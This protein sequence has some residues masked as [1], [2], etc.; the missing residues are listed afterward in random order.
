[1]IT[2]PTPC[3]PT[4][5]SLF[6]ALDQIADKIEAIFDNGNAKDDVIGNGL[7]HSYTFT[8][9]DLL[10]NDVNAKASTFF[11]GDGLD[12]LKQ[13]KYM[14]DHGIVDNHNGTYTATAGH[15]FEYSVFTTS[16]KCG[17]AYSVADV[18]VKDFV[19]HQGNLLFAD[20]FENYTNVQTSDASGGWKAVDLSKGN[21]GG[22]S[23]TD[24]ATEVTHTN[25][26][27]LVNSSDGNYWLDTQATTGGINISHLFNDPNGGK[28][29]VSFDLSTENF[30]SIF[31]GAA[32]DP[33]AAFQ[34]R[35]DDNGATK[36]IT[37]QD[38]LNKTGGHDNQMA[39]FDFVVD[40]TG[41][42]DHTLHLADV[43][44]ADHASPFGF[45][46]DNVQV[47]DWIV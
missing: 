39:H 33:H 29:E 15:D 22:W 19:P 12:A 35:I 17:G 2:L 30:T 31:Q 38:I 20:S 4:V 14:A 21:P 18:D 41:A 34:F 10:A 16:G 37:V 5:K 46:L 44:P 42:G 36:T 24:T 27:G 32:T 25:Y 9:A 45:A 40:V 8:I 11:F 23:S 43:T 6:P 1:M 28:V 47:H 7:S 13:A 3:A 26:F